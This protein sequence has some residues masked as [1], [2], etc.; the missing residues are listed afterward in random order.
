MAFCFQIL[1]II[2]T[3]ISILSLVMAS[4]EW[5]AMIS[6]FSH[7]I[8]G[9]KESGFWCGNLAITIILGVF[10]I[11]FLINILKRKIKLSFLL[12]LSKIPRNLFLKG[13]KLFMVK[14][15]MAGIDHS[16][17][18]LEDRELIQFFYHNFHYRSI[19]CKMYFCFHFFSRCNCCLK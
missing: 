11:Y 16:R 15:K 18:S 7:I 6:E 2:I 5:N 10:L 13:I 8:Q 3:I 14:I 12:L 4:G 9:I 17:V 19:F 1:S